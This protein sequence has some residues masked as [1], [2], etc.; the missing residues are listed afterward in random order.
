MFFSCG[1]IKESVLAICHVAIGHKRKLYDFF[2]PRPRLH[3]HNGTIADNR[4]S[5]LN[6]LFN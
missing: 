3:Q 2:M 1:G 6:Y 4:S 5:L